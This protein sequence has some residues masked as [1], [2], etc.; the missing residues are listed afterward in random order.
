MG[1]R[2]NEVTT[3]IILLAVLYTALGSTL[4]V[5]LMKWLG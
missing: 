2:D 5:G 3:E 4:L 1:R